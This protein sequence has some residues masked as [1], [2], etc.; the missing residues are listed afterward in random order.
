MKKISEIISFKKYWE[1]EKNDLQ[2]NFVLW[3]F[4]HYVV[5][6]INV[7][8]QSEKNFPTGTPGATETK[9]MNTVL[10]NTFLHIK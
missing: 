2:R 4:S 1:Q 10:D 5:Q 3:Q 8:Y 6:I 7:K 9:K